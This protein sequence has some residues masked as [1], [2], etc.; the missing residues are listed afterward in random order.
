M[1][2]NQYFSS[3]QNEELINF[4]KQFVNGTLTCPLTGIYGSGMNGKT[5]YLKLLELLSENNGIDTIFIT[6]DHL[7]DGNFMMT[8]DHHYIIIQEDVLISNDSFN[9]IN[10]LSSKLNSKFIFLTNFNPVYNLPPGVL[11]VINMDIQFQNNDICNLNW[12]D[13]SKKQ[14]FLKFLKD[15]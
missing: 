5:T 3:L 1:N 15:Y 11:S 13:E 10:L 6:P 9:K 2:S 4:G 14:E 7:N 12:V 8:L